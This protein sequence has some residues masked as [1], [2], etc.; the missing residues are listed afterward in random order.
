MVSPG[1]TVLIVD[2]DASK[3]AELERIF[4]EAGYTVVAADNAASAIDL[5]YSHPPQ[6]VIVRHGMKNAAD[7]PLLNAIKMDNVY[8]SLPAILIVSREDLERGVDWLHI[9]A[10]D[11]FMEPFDPLDAAN[12]VSLCLTRAQRDINANPLTGLPGNLTI[13]REAEKRLANGQFFAFAH[14]DIDHFKAFNDRY[15]FSRGDEILRMTARV[16][17]N[18]IRS[19]G[20]ED[21]YVGHI[22]GDDYVFITPSELIGKACE[23]IVSDFDLIAPDFYDQN[24]RSI[25]HIESKDRQGVKQHFPVMSISIG[26]VD[27]SITPV[28]H[29]ADMFARVNQV[30]AYAKKLPGSN[31]IID[32]RKS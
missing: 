28:Q 3:L 10:D 6:A 27:T 9:P 18:A 29:L 24:D 4:A 12:R 15:G 13:I 5:F 25:G 23:R 30:K 31:F 21:S 16:V 32:R 11:Y 26:A 22:G 7:R 14:V 2:N 17:V 8:G 19:L 20:N 1:V